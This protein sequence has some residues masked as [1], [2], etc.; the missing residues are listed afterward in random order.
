MEKQTGLPKNI[1]QIGE[2]DRERKICLEDYVM[3]CIREKRGSGELSGRLFWRKSGRK[4]E[5]SICISGGSWRR[6]ERTGRNCRRESKS[7]KKSIFRD[8]EAVGCCVIGAYPPG[9]LEQL[10]AVLPQA[11]NVSL[12]SPGAGRDALLEGR[13]KI[14]E[15]EGIFYLFMSK[16][17]RCRNILRI[18][19]PEDRVE[20]ESLPDKA[21]KSFRKKIEGK[22]QKRAAGFLK[23][24]SSFFVVTVLV[25]GTIAV[26]RLD[27]IRNTS[28]FREE[29]TKQQEPEQQEPEQEVYQ[30][31]V[32]EP[33]SETALP[34]TEAA[35]SF[36][37][38][39]TGAAAGTW[40]TEDV[41]ATGETQ[42]E[43]E[44]SPEESFEASAQA[45]QIRS[46]YVIKEGDTLA[47]ICTKYYGNL[48][49]LSELCQLNAITDADLV[50]PGQKIM[51]P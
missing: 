22:E 47:D 21:I 39:E 35:E 20:K 44:E 31:E 29:E 14:Q 16:T 2:I 13:R 37:T 1:R 30:Q 23:I 40:E 7:R 24:A 15:P 28:G 17:G 6:R 48:D 19:F 3:T 42:E 9:R 10:A 51:L 25:I 5:R 49:R 46:S 43:T 32:A 38:E 8:W 27:E 26:N 33:L 41:S 45:R 4:K 34:Q 50:V 11:G 12:S 18:C 36:E